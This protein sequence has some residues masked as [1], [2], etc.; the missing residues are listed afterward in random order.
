MQSIR[1]RALQK[2]QQSDLPSFMYQAVTDGIGWRRVCHSA[3]HDIGRGEETSEAI[4]DCDRSIR[5]DTSDRFHHVDHGA[6][7]GEKRTS[8]G[9][10]Y[11]SSCRAKSDPD[12]ISKMTTADEEGDEALFWLE[13]LVEAETRARSQLNS[14]QRSGSTEID[15]PPGARSIRTH[16]RPWRPANWRRNR[17]RSTRSACSSS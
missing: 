7:V 10:N 1:D 12:F 11:R 13:V 4:R 17:R 6:A 2:P 3:F 9:A 5:T 14:S 8:V 16:R 15:N